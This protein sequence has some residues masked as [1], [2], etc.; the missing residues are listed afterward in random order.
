MYE[1]GKKSTNEKEK[2]EETLQREKSI[3]LI[4]KKRIEQLIK[5]LGYLRD[6]ITG[7]EKVGP[8]YK[9]QPQ[10]VIKQLQEEITQLQEENKQLKVKKKRQSQNPLIQ[11]IRDVVSV[12]QTDQALFQAL[13][14]LFENSS[15]TKITLN[16]KNLV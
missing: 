10:D 4:R 2:K 8:S 11:E 15:A 14:T 7:K 9:S 13:N 6:V 16:E 1:M 5:K 12:C 3:L